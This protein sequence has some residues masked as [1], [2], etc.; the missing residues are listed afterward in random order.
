MEF[1]SLKLTVLFMLTLA[2]RSS[3]FLVDEL[4]M[5]EYTIQSL[6]SR[7]LKF[8]GDSSRK[9]SQNFDGKTVHSFKPRKNTGM[10]LFCEPRAA[11]REPQKILAKKSKNGHFFEYPRNFLSN[12]AN[13]R[14]SY[15]NNLNS[16]S[17]FLI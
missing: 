17:E 10:R 14:E 2:E 4:P 8:Y 16:F 3:D 1:W 12:R 15:S 13:Q 6:C 7:Q 5:L 9:L 11:S